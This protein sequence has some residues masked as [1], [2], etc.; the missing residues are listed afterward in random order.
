MSYGTCSIHPTDRL[1]RRAGT[2]WYATKGCLHGCP[3]SGCPLPAPSSVWLIS[4]CCSPPR[5]PPF[6][7]KP[8]SFGT[9]QAIEVRL[10]GL[11]DEP[12][13]PVLHPPSYLGGGKA[14][15]EWSTGGVGDAGDGAPDGE[16]DSTAAAAAAAASAGGPAASDND[17]GAPREE[18]G[19]GDHSLA[20]LPPPPPATSSP[21]RAATFPVHKYVLQRSCPHSYAAA[22]FE[23]GAGGGAAAENRGTGG[24]GGGFV[25]GNSGGGGWV[26]V[27]EADDVA[28]VSG[29]SSFVFVDSGLS[30]GKT[31]VYR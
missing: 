29:S 18:D 9:K 17:D 8:F 11:G 19:V 1:L 3:V 20:M 26:T 7:A 12:P 30:P 24:R 6:A 5:P 2:A 31:Y 21:S 27:H 13:L 23:G 22:A 28:S 14:R 16:G 4:S 15:I 25:V 10:L